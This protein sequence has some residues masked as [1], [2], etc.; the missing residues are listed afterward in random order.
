MKTVIVT[1]AAALTACFALPAQAQVSV[2]GTGL[3]HQCYVQ[4]KYTDDLKAGI[5]IC[6]DALKTEAMNSS[7]RASTLIN[8]AI[9]KARSGDAD[10]A[11]GDYGSALGIGSRAGEAYL[12]RSATLI[13]MKRYAD[14]QQDA[15]RAVQF[16]TTRMEVAYYNRGLANEQLGNIQAAYEDFKAA[17]RVEP[18]FTAAS[19]ELQHFRIKGT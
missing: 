6:D 2:I 3:A 17:L 9:M 7:D 14:A 13:A 18:N 12:N 4:A 16:G 19:E 11:M 5:S 1:A 10:G 15:D 8:R